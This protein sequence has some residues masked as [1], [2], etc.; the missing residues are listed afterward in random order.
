MKQHIRN[1]VK[2]LLGSL[3]LLVT[4]LVGMQ[5]PATVHATSATLT[6][7]ADKK[8]V[9][10]GETFYVVVVLDSSENIGGFEGYISYDASKAEFVSGGSLVSGGD[11]LLRISEMDSSE[12]ATTKKYSIQ[13]TAKKTGDCVFDTSDAPAVYS[14]EGDELSVSSNKLTISIA[15]SE[16]LSKNNKL[17]K[18][19]IS[20]STL[21]QEYSNDVTAYKTEIPYENEMLFISAEPEDEDAIV[22]VEGNEGLKVGQNYVHVVVVA[23]SGAKRDIQIEVTRMGEEDSN[24]DSQQEDENGITIAVDENEIITLLIQHK[25]QV[26]ELKDTSLIPEGYELSDMTID[27]QTIP[28]YVESND[29]QSEFLLFYLTNENGEADF[30]QYD[31]VE[32]TIQRYDGE[33]VK[34][35]PAEDSVLSTD[36]S[37]T[38]SLYYVLIAA[39][40]G[41]VIILAVALT[42][43]V[44]KHR[45]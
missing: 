1:G 19:L 12:P 35:I 29:K 43:S 39:L 3:L 44:L 38:D 27:G 4:V 34:E 14:E 41:L 13:F 5:V 23:P 9:S 25:Y 21:N 36:H 10:V 28:T 2:C 11:G 32:K 45:K 18:L 15:N 31:R 33:Q 8:S 16:S 7:T 42:V 40:A 37:E 30:Y 24:S 17:K 22:T 26:A 6:F 20:P